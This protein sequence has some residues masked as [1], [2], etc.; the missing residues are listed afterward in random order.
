MLRITGY[1]II[2]SDTKVAG[3]SSFIVLNQIHASYMHEVERNT[4]LVEVSID[5]FLV[6]QH[7]SVFIAAKGLPWTT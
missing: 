7:D 2:L 3:N 4:F 5:I 6:V 1:T